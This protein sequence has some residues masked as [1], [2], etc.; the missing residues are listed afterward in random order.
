[1]ISDDI[2]KPVTDIPVFAHSDIDIPF[3][4]YTLPNGLRL[5]VHEDHKAPIVA[6]NIWYHV[7]SKNEKPGKSGFAHLFEHLM[8]NGSEHFNDDYFQALLA[9][10]ATDLNGTTN[11]DR[12]N[13]FQN[14][15]T[16]ALDQVLWLESDRM[17]HLL[18]ALDQAKLD[19]QRG[20]VQNEKRQRENV[21]YGCEQEI[22]AQE[23]YPKGHPYSWT[24]IGSMDDIAGATLED[25]REWFKAYYGAANAVL[26]IAG[27]VNP[28]DVLGRVKK[29]FG[30]IPPG[31]ALVRPQLNIPRRNH[32]TRTTYQDRVPE[33]RVVMVW[34]SPQ[35]GSREDA[36]L[37]LASDILARGKNSR[38]YKTLIYDKKIASSVSAYQWAK[39]IAGNFVIEAN[40]KP[41][42]SIDEVEAQIESI[43][44]E[45]LKHGPTEEELY[46]VRAQYFSGFIKGLERIGGFGGKSDILASSTIYGGTPDAYKKYN[47]YIAHATPEEIRDACRAWLSHGKFTLT[48]HPLPAYTVSQEGA[49]RTQM[50]ALETVRAGMFPDLERARLRNGLEIILAHRSAVPTVVV[51]ALIHAGFASDGIQAGLA[52][53][54]M[55][56]LDEGTRSLN[57]LE[58]NEQLQLLG[59]SLQCSASLD[60]AF[61]RLS[62]LKQSLPQSLSLFGEILVHP[63]FPEHELNRIKKEYHASI[64]R[65]K[66][67]PMPMALRVVPKLLFGA[68]HRY[69]QP[70]TGTGYE[71]TLAHISRDDIVSFYQTW[72]RPSNTKLLVVGDLSM[73]EAKSMVSSYLQDWIDTLVPAHQ[74][75]EDVLGVSGTLFLLDRPGSQQSIVIGGYLVESYNE[76][77]AIAA[78]QM[79][80]ILGGHFIS[81]INMNLREDKHWTYGARSLILDTEGE[82]PFL[83]FASVQMD[84]TRESIE[85]IRKEFEQFVQDKPVSQAEFEK[86]LKNAIL[87]LPGQ[88]ETNAAVTDSLAAMV[89]L[90]LADN[91]FQTFPEQLRSLTLDEVHTVS[92]RLVR[93][94]AL[95]WFVVGDREKIL[96]SLLETGFQSIVHIDVEGNPITL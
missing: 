47:T 96:P 61:V 95:N 26:V 80:D 46:R 28:Q 72:I 75:P 48:C 82:R 40:A 35:I 84:K 15:P 34:I 53:L 67:N 62:T 49:D 37:G 27:D 23:I 78:E 74:E 30:D 33:A 38:L 45:F 1:M 5:I 55:S 22:V 94:A 52:S 86:N 63:T 13:Y 2:A 31:P 85:E 11:H 29:Y 69:A 56:M 88:W 4:E 93:P 43:F 51:E 19:E 68:G 24:V 90:N 64:Q 25:C 71:S 6:V 76:E 8:F 57:A 66:V 60:H 32:Y 59:A 79:N 50:P 44:H 21:P 42:E 83:V 3:V 73:Y 16:A 81:R 14:V 70:L 91:Y 92:K 20:V 7:G 36:L 39:E 41:G 58:I 65:E 12:T 10:G 17:G 9:V 87:A 54:T 89:K 18:G 77:T